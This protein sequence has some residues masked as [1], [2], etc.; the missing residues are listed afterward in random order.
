MGD[1]EDYA[2]EERDEEG[3]ASV[4]AMFEFTVGGIGVMPDPADNPDGHVTPHHDAGTRIS[5]E[6]V[7]IGAMGGVARVSVE[8]DDQFIEERQS[9]QIEP[10]SSW[11]DYVSLG[12]LSE[13]EH[14]VLVYVNPG[15]G[16]PG[17]DHTENTFNVE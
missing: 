15:S 17:S 1:S 6:V 2:D 11:F 4:G 16:N 8:I 12:R 10:G 14:T 3:G 5:F 7:N 13:G 9:E